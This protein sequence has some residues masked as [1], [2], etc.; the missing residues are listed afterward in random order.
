[1]PFTNSWLWTRKFLGKPFKLKFYVVEC[2][3]YL[4][5]LNLR[6]SNLKFYINEVNS[7]N[8]TGLLNCILLLILILV[9]VDNK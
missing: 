8:C 5:V 2:L 9:L 6:F 3:F 1:M 4:N 7:L